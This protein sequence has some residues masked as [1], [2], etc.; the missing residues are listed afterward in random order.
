MSFKNSCSVAINNYEWYTSRI[1][2]FYE[3]RCLRPSLSVEELDSTVKLVSLEYLHIPHDEQT[4]LKHQ[5][6]F[7]RQSIV[8]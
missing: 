7:V 2:F 8:F 5:T 3:M 4:H 6:Q 1:K